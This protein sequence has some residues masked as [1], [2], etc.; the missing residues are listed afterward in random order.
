MN[1][2][3]IE[4]TSGDGFRF[5][6][7]HVTAQGARKGGLVLVQEIFGVNS[8]MIEACKRFAAEGYE[9][10]APSMF[11]RQDKGF[12]TE[13]HSPDAIAQG[14]GYARA[15]GLE[16]AMADI[17]TCIGELEAPVFITGFCKW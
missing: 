7:L 15:N 11:D 8:Y 2:K 17:A 13:S 12:S 1:T 4:L 9:V 10:L 16:N 5:N 14:G 6:A 3:V